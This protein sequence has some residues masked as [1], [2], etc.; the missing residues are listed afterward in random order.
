MCRPPI[1]VLHFLYDFIL[2]PQ[3]LENPPRKYRLVLDT[4]RNRI[5]RDLDWLLIL[6]VFML[7]PIHES[8]LPQYHYL[9]HS[10]RDL[11]PLRSIDILDL[12]FLL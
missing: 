10:S 8:I 11:I 9:S 1:L 3:Y 4:I 6:D 2:T 7:N 5:L 12:S